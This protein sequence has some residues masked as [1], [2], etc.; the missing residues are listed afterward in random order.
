[1]KTK[2]KFLAATA[3][4]ILSSFLLI[5][6]CGGGGDSGGPVTPDVAAMLRSGTWKVKT[7]TVDGTN[8]IGL[9]TGLTLTF[10]SSA[11]SAANGNPVWPT[12]GT[13]T[14]NDA[15]TI[16]TRGDGL[17]VTINNVTETALG[18]SLVWSKTTLGGG[19]AESVEGTHLFTFGK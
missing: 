18:L 1:M 19:R 14:L 2:K 5:C 8:Q 7:V 4:M 17:T 9:F 12:T 10:S 15:G 16:I 3:A 6:S 11:F 13:W